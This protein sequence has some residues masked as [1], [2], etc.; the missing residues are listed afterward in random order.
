S[1][2]ASISACRDP[3][4]MSASSLTLLDAL[5]TSDGADDEHAA[6]TG[7][8]A[9]SI[10]HPVFFIVCTAQPPGEGIVRGRRFLTSD[11][12]RPKRMTRGG[13]FVT[14][15]PRSR[16]IVGLIHGQSSK[17]IANE[18]WTARYGSS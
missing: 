6:R 14:G 18:M 11:R 13:R 15:P 5:S 4:R 7:S 17:T 3:R 10:I 8:T 1:A 9:P 2:I 12:R 16:V